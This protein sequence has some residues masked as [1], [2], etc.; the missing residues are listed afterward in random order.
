MVTHDNPLWDMLRL[1][2]FHPNFPI[3]EADLNAAKFVGTPITELV[4][5]EVRMQN[6]NNLFPTCLCTGCGNIQEDTEYGFNSHVRVSCGKCR[7]RLQNP[8][9][10]RITNSY[11]LRYILFPIGYAPSS[12]Y[13]HTNY[14][15]SFRELN[16]IA[17]D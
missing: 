10:F 4:P 5:L 13:L 16:G 8:N 11:A 15:E 1:L 6:N 7:E 12:F 2:Y 9:V 3:T 14:L 17:G